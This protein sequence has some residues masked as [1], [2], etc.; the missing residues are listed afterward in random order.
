[1]L[2][3]RHFRAGNAMI[4]PDSKFYVVGGVVRTPSVSIVLEDERSNAVDLGVDALHAVSAGVGVTAERADTGAI[5]YSGGVSLAIGV[6]LYAVSYDSEEER[7]RMKPADRASPLKAR[8]TPLPAEFI[9]ED[10]E[11]L[12]IVT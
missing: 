6:E 8:L 2:V 11:A 12:L 7:F 9:A 1:V 3:G 5:T 4:Q 10:D